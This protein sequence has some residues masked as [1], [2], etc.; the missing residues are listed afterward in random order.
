MEGSQ[1]RPLD[2]V[3]VVD[4][5]RVLAGPYCTMVL[6]DLGADVVKV[7]RPQGGDETRS[8]GPP[9]V[10]GEAAYFLAVNRGKRSAAIDLANPAGR[11]IARELCAGADVVVENFK[12]GGAERL[13]VGYES[14]RDLNPRV[15]YC[16]IS[17]FGSSRSPAGRPG[18]DFVAQAESG[19]MS[20]TGPAGRR[21]LQGRRGSGG[22]AGGPPRLLRGARRPARRRGRAHRGAA[23]GQCPRRAGERGPER[24]GHGSRAGATRE[25]A[26]EHRAVPGLR[27][28]VRPPGRGRGQRRTVRRAVRGHGAGGPGRGR[29][30]RHQRG[31]GG[32]PGRA[33][34]RSSSAASPSARRRSGSRRW[35][36]RASP[37]AR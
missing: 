21:P 12:A 1:H 14:V 10:A 8:W 31:P 26:S 35:R 36:P 33:G 7:E 16:S 23:A 5:S 27:H 15:V 34:A 6:A 22:R 4:L 25:R 17:G 13:G 24:P 28:G 32:A 30:L 11:E 19:L 37:R 3:R 9:F 29:A 2:G 20:I 18:Y